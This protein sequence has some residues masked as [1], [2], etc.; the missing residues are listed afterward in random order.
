[1]LIIVYLVLCFVV[2]LAG[3]RRH[4]GFIGYFLL[5]LVLTPILPLAFLVMTHKKFLAKQVAA[6]HIVICPACA[7]AQ[8]EA[9][10]VRHC[11]ICGTHL[12]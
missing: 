12:A 8:Q 7:A 11:A 6:G 1:M 3:R 5:S 9:E 4:V 10:S 2:G